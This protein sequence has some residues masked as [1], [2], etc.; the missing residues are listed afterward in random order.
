MNKI[1][2][3]DVIITIQGKWALAAIQL[4][5]PAEIE[6]KKHKFHTS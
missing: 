1:T 5:S 2:Y 3:T 6:K 4:L